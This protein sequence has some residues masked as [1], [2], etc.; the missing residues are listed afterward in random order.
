MP[1]FAQLPETNKEKEKNRFEET[2]AR[3]ETNTFEQIPLSRA[4][5]TLICGTNR[6]NNNTSAVVRVYESLL[7]KSGQAVELIYLEQ[8]PHDFAYRNAVLGDSAPE[9]EAI[10]ERCIRP[11]EKLVILSPEYNG[12]FPGV[13]KAFIDAIY[14]KDLRGKKA[15]LVGVASGRAG[16]LRGL[17]HL[18]NILN[19]LNLV[20]LPFKVPISGIEALMQNGELVDDQT[21]ETLSKQVDQFI[22]F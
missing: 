11:A 14:P 12:G 19:Y 16:N 7:K 17:D 9:L 15:A 10:I 13:L 8:L 21:I 2:E 5:I 20:V 6:P 4:M 1:L 3:V 22:S 18:T